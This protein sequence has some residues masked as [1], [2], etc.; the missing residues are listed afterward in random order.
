MKQRIGTKYSF[1]LAILSSIALSQSLVGKAPTDTTL[2]VRGESKDLPAFK[3]EAVRSLMQDSSFTQVGRWAWG[4]CNAVSFRSNYLFVGNGSLFQVLDIS[5]VDSPKVVA[6]LLTDGPVK[7][8]EMVG[9][10]ALTLAGTMNVIDI[11]DPNMPVVVSTGPGGTFL[12]V[13]GGYAYVGNFSG[14]ISIVDILDPHAVRTVGTMSTTGQFVLSIAV[15]GDYLYATSYDGL[16]IDVF[17]IA[18]KTVPTY[19][20]SYG[21]L[22]GAHALTIQGDFLY[23][24]DWGARPLFQILNVSAGGMPI[25]VGGLDMPGYILSISIRDSLAYLARGA[26]GLSIVNMADKANP[27]EVGAI[28]NQVPFSGP[29]AAILD[30]IH[31][32]LPSVV[33]LWIVSVEPSSNPT[34]VSFFHTSST[35][36]RLATDSSGHAYLATAATGLKVIDLSDPYKPGLIGSYLVPSEAVDVAYHDAKAFLLTRQDLRVVDVSN[37]RN[38]TLLG[39]LTFQDTLDDNS[40]FGVVG[41]IAVEG[42]RAVVCRSSKKIYAIDIARPD[43]PGVL[44]VVAVPATPIDVALSGGYVYVAEGARGVEVYELTGAS[45]MSLVDT[46]LNIDPRGLHTNGAFLFVVEYGLT[47]FDLTNPSQ[48]ERRGNVIPPGGGLVTADLNSSGPYV[49]LDFGVDFFIADASDPWNPRIVETL[50]DVGVLALAATGN[51]ILIGVEN[52]GFIVLKNLLLTSSLEEKR[53]GFPQEIS[54]SQNYPNPFNS[55]TLVEYSIRER[56][57]VQISV[58]N[59]LGQLVTT[60]I[61]EVQDPGDHKVPYDGSGLSSGVYFFR[62]VARN[63]VQVKSAV[64]IK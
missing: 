4:A 62:I 57:H 15:K 33:G 3:R 52:G 60:L 56:T 59:V 26:R 23:L 47:V 36:H 38:P 40:G 35:I 8:I 49:Y 19:I 17:N 46:I 28:Y 55:R 39:L 11:S 12:A 50:R 2:A 13:A 7:A 27:K 25:Y 1:F 5:Q 31:A 41:S 42:S 45:S 58:F 22:G 9:S 16:M 20:G 54:F 51:L 6:E 30:S 48:P 43:Q 10:Y 24:A 64:M 34:S 37:P 63:F 53:Q 14:G 18:D 29:T 32:Y 61:D 44:S 21:S